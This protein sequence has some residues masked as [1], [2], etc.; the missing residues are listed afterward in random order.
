MR[1]FEHL[2]RRDL[3]TA[4]LDPVILI[5][6][7][8]GTFA[9]GTTEAAANT[10]L[11]NRGQPP[12]QLALEP[13][14]G[15]YQNVVQSLKNVGYND[16]AASPTQSLF[17]VNWDW[18]LPLA[19]TDANSLSAP[20]GTLSSVTAAGISDNVFQTGLDYF[21]RVLADVKVKYPTATKVDV[22]G[23]GA[24]GLIARSYI[25]SA[26]Y[27]QGGLPTIDDLVLI[28]TPNEGMSDA[29]NFANNDW[30]SRSAPRMM[31]EMVDRA[32]SL[33]Q[34]GTTIVGP[35]GNITPSEGLN[36]QQFAQRYIASLQNLLPTY[37]VIDTN[38]DGNFEPLSS[39]NPPGNNLVNA[40]LVDL[41]GGTSN[42]WLSSPAKTHVV[43]ATGSETS[44]Q[45]IART[46][47]SDDGFSTDEILSFQNFRGRRPAAG[48]TWYEEVVSGHGGD[49]LVS[50][51]S[52]IDPFLGDPRTGGKLKLIPVTA[53]AAGVSEI[54]HNALV[55]NPYAQTKILQSVGAT[56]FTNA[57]L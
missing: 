2:E 45:L 13:F 24:G 25:Q 27:N 20:N 36:P 35:N 21:G 5:P 42:A 12:A 38:D 14:T 56:N 43:Y 10:W 44:D 41:N 9:A 37:D 16:S 39:S 53:A 49:G 55:I 52:S 26:A 51:F 23:H 48:E 47:P 34:S 40:L 17:V 28:G 30:S 57:N 11:A 19:P 3:L 22:I 33:L 31:T 54:S 8:G 32:Y 1:L 6:G 7:L 46:G 29:F 4:G 18:R 50:T 15:V